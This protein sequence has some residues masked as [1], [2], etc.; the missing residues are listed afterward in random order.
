MP[1][2]GR[3]KVNTNAGVLDNNRNIMLK[4]KCKVIK[5]IW[6]SMIPL[7]LTIVHNK[8]LGDNTI[9][10]GNLGKIPTVKR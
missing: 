5:T 7:R 9:L 2:N 3:S 1:T 10:I 8:V 6:N 4:I